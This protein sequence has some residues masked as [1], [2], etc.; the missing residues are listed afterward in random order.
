[1]VDACVF[2]KI[3]LQEEKMD[4]CEEYLRLIT[5]RGDLICVTVGIIHE[6]IK[7]IEKKVDEEHNSSSAIRKAV[8]LMIRNDS[9]Y[10]HLMVLKTIISNGAILFPPEMKE[11][12][13][14]FDDCM[15]LRLQK[16]ENSHWDRFHLAFAISNH[17]EE[18][19]TTDENIFNLQT[20]IDSLHCP[21]RLKI[22]LL[23]H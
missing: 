10:T 13:T 19:V 3:V 14:I 15:D 12:K 18:F 20:E 11:S 16:I 2:L 23:G 4:E 22:T 1:M 8:S 6:I 5:S 17:C 21:K 9:L 7:R